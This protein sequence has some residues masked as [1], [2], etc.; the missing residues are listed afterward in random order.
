M[1]NTIKKLSEKQ[2]ILQLERKI[3]KLEKII[4]E[5]QISTKNLKEH[6]LATENYNSWLSGY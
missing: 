6:N 2:R 3:A 4:N 1:N 5:I